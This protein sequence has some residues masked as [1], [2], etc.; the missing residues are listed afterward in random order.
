MNEV[1]EYDKNAS[2]RILHLFV[3][4]GHEWKLCWILYNLIFA[5]FIYM[6][7]I[8]TMREHKR[9]HASNLFL[10]SKFNHAWIHVYHMCTINKTRLRTALHY[11]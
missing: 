9:E 7:T 2:L 10:I 5:T 4:V 6:E 8:V 11:V 3:V 1:I